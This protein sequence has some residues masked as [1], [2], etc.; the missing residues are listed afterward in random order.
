[1]LA[2]G[3][4]QDET[5]F[6]SEI[7]NQVVQTSVPILAYYPVHDFAQAKV[8]QMYLWPTILPI[9]KSGKVA[10][11]AI[12]S[13][14]PA[15]TY[16]SVL[17]DQIDTFIPRYSSNF[18]YALL[19]DQDFK[20]V[21]EYEIRYSGTEV[22]GQVTSPTGR[23]IHYRSQ[24]DEIFVCLTSSDSPDTAIR[25]VTINKAVSLSRHHDEANKELVNYELESYN[26]GR[27]PD[28]KVNQFRSEGFEAW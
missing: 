13:G 10:A 27:V 5:V 8:F 21:V 2:G 4:S 26:V 28:F 24:T 11:V 20:T 18:L 3:Y 12:S 6:N 23:S 19:L 17:L 1:M 15:P 22:L 9:G 16:Y 14:S 25:L 7:D